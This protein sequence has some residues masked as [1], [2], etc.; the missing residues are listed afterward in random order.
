MTQ[1]VGFY[2]VISDDIVTLA[3]PAGDPDRDF[4][5][6]PPANAATDNPAI[7]SFMFRITKA[8]NM[9]FNIYL[10][11]TLVGKLNESGD[12][13]SFYLEAIG[14]NI[15]KPGSTNKLACKI[16]SGS[17][18]ISFSDMVLWYQRNI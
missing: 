5:F 17:G 13:R 6:N 18:S 3:Q 11:G 7:L 1:H 8:S 12:F 2:E 14:A 10:N 4:F 9:Q 16:Q 15:I